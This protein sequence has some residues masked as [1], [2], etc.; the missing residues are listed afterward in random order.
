MP[1]IRAIKQ[2]SGCVFCREILEE[3]REPDLIV[4]RGSHAFVVL[5][6]Y[7]YTT[8]HLMIVPY[9]HVA[10]LPD[11]TPD[12]QGEMLRLLRI[13]ELLVEQQVGRCTIQA[14]INIGRCAG[15]G[16]EGHLHIH[17]VPLVSGSTSDSETANLTE[18]P[19][20]LVATRERFRASWNEAE[21]AH[22][23]SS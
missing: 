14:G 9:R 21:E 10:R 11:L 6:L 4:H 19:E 18:P 15:A 3:M 1:Y 17:L 12:E 7:P 20:P 2:D 13:S 5:N 22:R 16:V 8:G 23:A